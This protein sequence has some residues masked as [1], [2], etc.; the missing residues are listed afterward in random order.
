MEAAASAVKNV[1]GADT[2]IEATEE[3]GSGY[4]GS[5]Y[6]LELTKTAKGATTTTK[7]DTNSVVVKV[8]EGKKSTGFIEKLNDASVTES[9]SKFANEHWLPSL[10]ACE[11]AAYVTLAKWAVSQTPKLI[12]ASLRSDH[13]PAT[14]VMEDLTGIGGVVDPDH[15]RP[16]QVSALIK[17]LAEVH[18]KSIASDAWKDRM[19][20]SLQLHLAEFYSYLTKMHPIEGVI[21]LGPGF[22]KAK[23]FV[24]FLDPKS[25]SD[26]MFCVDE[27]ENLPRVFV[28]GDFFPDN[29]LWDPS[30]AGK[31]VG[32]VD[33]QFAHVGSCMEDLARILVSSNDHDALTPTKIDYWLQCYLTEVLRLQPAFPMTLDQLRRALNR[34]LPFMIMEYALNIVQDLKR[35]T[36]EGEKQKYLRIGRERFIALERIAASV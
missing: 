31:L 17:F 6:R 34:K 1:F 15:Y 16:E 36:S 7:I 27:D 14:F 33:W 20:Q 30:D 13:K 5:V 23:S 2:L 24:K 35:V 28:H 26:A 9:W 11:E 10:Y 4:F 8:L 12:G 25:F 21:A 22:E 3:I 32:V 18:V 29:T 19:P